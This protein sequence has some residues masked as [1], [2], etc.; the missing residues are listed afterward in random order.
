MITGGTGQLVA[1]PTDVVK[2][3]MQ[4]DGRLRLLGK[5]PRY[6]GPLDAFRRIPAEEGIK[7]ASRRFPRGAECFSCSLRCA[8]GGS[9]LPISLVRFLSIAGFFNG[10]R[11]SVTRAAIINGCGIASYDHTKQMT[12]KLTGQK[13]GTTEAAS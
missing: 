5:E 8:R 11:P 7:G 6:S 13:V 12:L 3:R 4:A 2:V 10:V 1:S 9:H